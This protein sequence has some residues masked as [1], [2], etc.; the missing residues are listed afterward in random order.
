MSHLWLQILLVWLAFSFVSLPLLA[1]VE[2]YS[3]RV[4]APRQA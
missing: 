1:L 3:R 2:S 4:Q